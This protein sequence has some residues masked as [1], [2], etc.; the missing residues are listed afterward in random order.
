[1]LPDVPNCL[2][3]VPIML[4]DVPTCL[5]E[6]APIMLPDVPT[7]LTKVPIMLPDVP[8]CLTEEVPIMLPDVPGDDSGKLVGSLLHKDSLADL[9][10]EEGHQLSPHLYLPEKGHGLKIR[11]Q[12]QPILLKHT[13]FLEIILKNLKFNQ[14]RESTNYGIWPFSISY[15]S[16][17]VH[18]VQNSQA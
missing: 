14:K 3:E 18:T 7:C 12:I 9:A 17:A 8:T 5:T 11:I 1:M 13:V 6:E 10:L 2:T 15:Y 4:P 16:P